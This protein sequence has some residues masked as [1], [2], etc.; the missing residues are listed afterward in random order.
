MED[1]TVMKDE[2]CVVQDGYYYKLFGDHLRKI[3]LPIPPKAY[4]KE[5]IE[6]LYKEGL[7]ENVKAEKLKFK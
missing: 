1:K 6:R 7:G 5:D 4:T 2:Y 3:E